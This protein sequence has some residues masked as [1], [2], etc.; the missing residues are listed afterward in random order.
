MVKKVGSRVEL[1][2]EWKA[3]RRQLGGCCCGGDRTTRHP[4]RRLR[5]PPDSKSHRHATVSPFCCFSIL[6]HVPLRSSPAAPARE[7][8]LIT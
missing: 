5:L 3:R 2:V 4:I 6:N 1:E 8:Q 7:A